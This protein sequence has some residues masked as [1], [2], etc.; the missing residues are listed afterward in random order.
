LAACGDALNTNDSV[1]DNDDAKDTLGVMNSQSL[2]NA[3][4]SRAEAEK[5]LGEATTF[6]SG[7]SGNR[8]QGN[9]DELINKTQTALAKTRTTLTDTYAV[10]Q[11]TV[12]SAVLTQAELDALK[13]DITGSRNGIDS[14]LSTLNTRE[15]AIASQKVANQSSLTGA[16]SAVNSAKSAQAVSESNLSAVKS[17]A[18][19]KINAAQSAITAREG[20]LKQ[21]K[22]SLNQVSAK[23][24]ASKIAAEQAQVRQAQAS[25][26]LINDQ[27]ADM[28]LT[29]PH[30]GVVTAVNGEVG[31]I[32]SMTEPFFTIIIPSGFEIK[33]NISEVEIAKLK[34]GDS[35]DITFDALGSEEKFTGD[36][37]EIDPAETVIS[38]V[39]YYKVTTL[40]AGDGEVVKPGM[41]ANLDI[42][43]A[44]KENVLKIPFQALK[45][46]DGSKYVQTVV[47]NKVKEIPVETGLKGDSDY[48]ITK[49]LSEGQ[50]VVTF[51]E[52]KK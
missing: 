35:V 18:T 33:A 43:T 38:G 24:P 29:T 28:I 49:G 31:E 11:S 7:V 46:R 4:V 39:I 44:K 16:E 12:T 26:D 47:D 21:A 36:I 15:Q 52:E 42:L 34:V 32:A 3:Q 50:E 8:T 51:L 23:T 5:T 13:A 9:I 20:D 27:L 41:T 1:L 17:G 30:E 6:Q 22:D 19:S 37:G 48:E 25:V 2:R 14:T 10:L 40:F 45:E